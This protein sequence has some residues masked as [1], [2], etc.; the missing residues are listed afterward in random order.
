M[1][2]R[3]VLVFA[4]NGQVVG[5][6]KGKGLISRRTARGG[7]PGGESPG[8]R[9]LRAGSDHW[10]AAP[11]RADSEGEGPELILVFKIS[12]DQMMSSGM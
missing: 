6:L 4:I 10:N 2:F 12:K 8:N 5:E 11:Y 9:T 1:A 3:L 7:G